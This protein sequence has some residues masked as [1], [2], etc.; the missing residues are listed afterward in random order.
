MEDFRYKEDM[1]SY[2]TDGPGIIVDDEAGPAIARRISNIDAKMHRDPESFLSQLQVLGEA[3]T[4][5]V[6]ALDDRE[7]RI[8]TLTRAASKLIVEFFSNRYD[9]D[10]SFDPDTEAAIA[11][12]PEHAKLVEFASSRK[13]QLVKTGIMSK[14]MRPDEHAP[15]AR[16]AV[17]RHRLELYLGRV[18]A[19]KRQATETTG[20]SSQAS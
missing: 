8:P 15:D 1:D 3:A 7:N 9:F 10:T 18:L 20:S 2:M 14:A 16:D 5:K 17:R 19:F 6:I 13:S 11:A 12:D 4:E